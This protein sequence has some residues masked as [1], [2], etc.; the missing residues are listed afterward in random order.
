MRPVATGPEGGPCARDDFDPG[1]RQLD[2]ML[3]AMGQQNGT[4]QALSLQG[5]GSRP[6]NYRSSDEAWR[7]PRYALM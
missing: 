2:F 3:S 4:A 1:Q 6:E 7:R 5:F